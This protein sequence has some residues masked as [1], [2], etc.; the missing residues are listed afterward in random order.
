VKRMTVWAG[1]VLSSKSTRAVGYARRLSRMGV[2]VI[3]VRPA[4]SVRSHEQP[5]VLRTRAGI[6]WPANE[7]ER[8]S[9]LEPFVRDARPD[10]LWIDEP[11]L[12]EDESCLYNVVQLLRQTMEIMLSGCPAT[13]ELEP[14]GVSF[15][16][17]LA[18]ADDI[19]W[20]KGDCDYTGTME[21]ATRSVCLVPKD[22]Q[23]LVGG[24]ESYKPASPEGWNRVHTPS[25]LH[26][27]L[28]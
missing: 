1:P 5:G 13:S 19:I 11:M 21:T 9:F 27:T 18:V 26:S 28:A 14:F 17:L 4:D 20:C 8:A 24:A 3:L 15:P 7:L 6:E 16:K 10:V 23:K 12:F 2:K 22:G 25:G